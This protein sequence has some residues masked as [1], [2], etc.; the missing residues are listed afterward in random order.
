MTL[1]KVVD[2]SALAAVV[3]SE[4]TRTAIE[5]RLSG[6]TL[7]APTLI[8]FEMASVCLKKIH[9]RPADRSAIFASHS[10]YEQFPIAKLPVVLREVVELAERLKLTLYDASFLWLSRSLGIEL[11]TLDN[12]LL[13]AIAK[14]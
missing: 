9:E 10:N 4:P 6:A 3:F 14:P 13:K 2:T 11:V 5:A 12:D 7:Y 1:A 8:D